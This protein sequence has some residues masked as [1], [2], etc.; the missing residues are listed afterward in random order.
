MKE[1]VRNERGEEEDEVRANEAGFG[2]IS[3]GHHSAC[4]CGGV[5]ELGR[6]VYWERNEERGQKRGVTRG[7][8]CDGARRRDCKV[9]ARFVGCSEDYFVAA[10]LSWID[11]ISTRPVA[12]DS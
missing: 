6:Q 9:V 1:L 10:S 7:C 5:A 8:W 12:V 11:N 3:S 2:S 4:G